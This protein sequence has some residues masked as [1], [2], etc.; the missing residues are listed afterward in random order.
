M[1]YTLKIDIDKVKN[2]YEIVNS[3]EACALNH[4][5]REYFYEMEKYIASI[6]TK[7]DNCMG[8]YKAK[9]NEINESVDKIKNKLNLL[10]DALRKTINANSDT[11]KVSEELS[12]KITRNI[13]DE[14][15]YK[16]TLQ[17]SSV[18]DDTRVNI[19][20]PKQE[21]EENKSLFPEGYNTTPIGLGIAAAGITGAVGAVV[22]DSTIPKSYKNNINKEIYEIDDNDENNYIDYEIAE[23]AEEKEDISLK[24]DPSMTSYQASRDKESMKK[25]YDDI[26]EE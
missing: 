8:N 3:I 20:I 4:N 2:S 24:I 16:K 25:F 1:A 14:L 13:S 7:H 11:A 9:L 15:Q 12:L 18:N 22:I 19:P 21:S 10:S 6:N 5:F 23:E 17:Q 26:D